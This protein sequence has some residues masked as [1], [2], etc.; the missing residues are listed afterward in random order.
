MR[1]DPASRALAPRSSSGEI[2]AFLGEARRVAPVAGGATRLIFALDATMSRQPTWDLAAEVQGA[3]FEAAASAGNLAVQLVYFRGLG[4]CR[5]SRWVAD[6]RALGGLMTTI[7]CRSGNTQI[8]RVLGHAAK[9]AAGDR[10]GALVY[11]GDAVEESLDELCA[12]A[13]ELGLLGTKA[14]MFHEGRH[15]ATV[16]GFAE[17]ARLTGGASLAF[18][19]AAPSTLAAL[20]AAVATYASGG[21]AALRRLASRDAAAGRLLA[22][23]PGRPAP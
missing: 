22:A 4:E 20:L 2:D 18:D 6:P 7:R 14:F 13:G 1:P 19:A 8:G 10:V 16:A 5:A 21:A 11:V 3:M 15:P 12:A 9:E 17:I 23:M